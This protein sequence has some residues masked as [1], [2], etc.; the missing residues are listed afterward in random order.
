M[1]IRSCERAVFALLVLLSAF[2]AFAEPFEPADSGYVVERL[3]S[4]RLPPAL[5]ETRRLRQQLLKKPDD[6]ELAADVARNYL[7]L[8]HAEGDPRYAG[9]AQMALNPWW[10]V[11]NPPTAILHLRASIRQ[12]NHD[13]KG[14]REDLDRALSTN[15]AD[16]QAELTKAFV[17]QAQGDYAGARAS[18]P[19]VGSAPSAALACLSSVDSFTGHAA[20]SDDRLS[21]AMPIY[22]TP[23]EKFWVLSILADIASREGKPQLADQRFREALNLGVRDV[24]FLSLYSDFLLQQNRPDAVVALL[25]DE[26]RVDMLLL[27]LAMAEKRLGLPALK[28]HVAVLKARFIAN[29][30]RGDIRNSR[31]EARFT[32]DLLEDAPTALAFSK[33][34][35]EIQKEP[36]D[37]TVLYQAAVATGDAAAIATVKEW[38]GRTKLED[39]YLKSLI[40]RNEKAVKRP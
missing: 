10:A 9:Y 36:E 39:A 25:K 17:L 28:D 23:E 33:T 40:T 26:T 20:Q 31:E 2:N 15:R 34:N 5:K 13:F 19:A 22:R 14:A 12:Y 1:T 4:R 27:R 32:L 11:P 37:L 30:L 3:Y 7:G 16:I 38:L 6:Q 8:A 35:W 18:C 24:L 21:R 29:R